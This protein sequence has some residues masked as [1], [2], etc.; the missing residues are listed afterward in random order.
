MLR[1]GDWLSWA[2]S[3]CRSVQ[4]N[5]GSPDVFSNPAS[6]I[7]SRS[8]NAPARRPT[9]AA[10]AAPSRITTT[11]KAVRI[12]R[13]RLTRAAASGPCVPEAGAG[14][15]RIGA[16]AADAAAVAAWA[17]LC[18]DSSLLKGAMNW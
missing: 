13:G 6:R 1:N 5:T 3:P 4:S 2:A 9:S 17:N 14:A 18:A 16:A 7:E 11:R 8:R 10:T 15:F 12:E